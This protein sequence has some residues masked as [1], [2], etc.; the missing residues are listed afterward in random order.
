MSPMHDCSQG[1]AVQ[2]TE[3]NLH[4]LWDIDRAFH[5]ERLPLLELKYCQ[6][7]TVTTKSITLLT[8]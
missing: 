4:G 8:I 3:Y 6:T 7:T 5:S 1:K 2:K